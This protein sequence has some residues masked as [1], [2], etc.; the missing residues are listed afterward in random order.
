[1]SMSASSAK[2]EA[3]IALMNSLESFDVVIVCCGK[4]AEAKYWQARLSKGRGSVIKESTTVLAV[5]EDWPGGAGN[6]LGT[7]YAYQNAAKLA[8]AEFSLDLDAKLGAGE[9]SVALYHT[10]GKGTR[11]APLPGA[12]NNNKPGVKLPAS[13]QLEGA[14]HP[15]T[16]LESVVK[17]TGCYAA[18]RLGRLSVF[19]G[20]QVF[21]PT[22]DVTYTPSYHADIL[23]TL[24]PMMNEEEWAEKGMDKY[25]LIAL[26]QSGKAAQVEKVT[27]SQ[28]LDLLQHLDAIQSVGASLGSFSVS[29]QML[30]ALL[31]EFAD[32]LAA[33][34]G[35]LD[36]DPHLW[37]P[38]TLER[39][40]Y[41]GVML[42][43]G[44]TEEV[45]GAHFDRIGAMMAKFHAVEANAS[46]GVFGPVDVG[47]GICWWDYGQ[48]PLYQK[49]SLL[50][51]GEGDESKLMR[52][53]FRVAE[54]DRQQ[55]ST[56][57]EGTDVCS[58]SVVNVS[59]V[60][61][62]AVKGSVLTNVFCKNIE[63][64]GCILMN[65]T[66]DS[67]VAKP[68]SIIYNIVSTEALVAEAGDVITGVTT[69]DGTQTII[70]SKMSIDGG[71]VWDSKVEGNE[72]T[73]GQVHGT[74]NATADPSELE[75]INARLHAEARETIS[76]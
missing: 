24:G 14:S 17:Q 32:D 18:S 3:N 62:G 51:L 36:S 58:N 5:H 70:R 74:V 1:M 68:G 10:A 53:Y 49:F 35:K 4:P 34:Q 60:R 46:M 45:A 33:K 19:W 71:K 48:L 59:S 39:A 30:F 66:A 28:A 69:A 16:I 42:G 61:S 2:I 76:K 22:V 56:L 52:S 37:M 20:D 40:A 55:G 21:I 15:I 9:I 13:V 44:V 54:N 29:N 47:Q 72:F 43:K 73:F 38:M 23:C 75:S 50:M 12:E 7:M 41:I 26:T 27:H 11:M 65:V 25:G 63:A 6:A 31:S 8:A 67:I 64:D 57:D